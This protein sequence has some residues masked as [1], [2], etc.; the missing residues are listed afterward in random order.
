MSTYPWIAAACLLL[1]WLGLAGALVRAILLAVRAWNAQVQ[2]ERTY[3]RA[4]GPAWAGLLLVWLGLT[5]ALL[6]SLM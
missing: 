2:H 6:H 1:I 4:V 3:A 5:N